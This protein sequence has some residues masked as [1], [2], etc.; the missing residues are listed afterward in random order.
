MKILYYLP[1]LEAPG[2]LERIITFKANY[3]AEHGDEVTI[4]TSEME[5]TKPHFALSPRVRHVDLGVAFDYPYSQSRVMKLLKY[6]FRYRRF[7]KRLVR[8]LHELRPD[9]TVSTLRRELNFLNDVKDGSVKI[10]EFH[11]TRHA[12]GAEA[13]TSGNA[14]MRKLKGMWNKRFV[15]NLSRLSRVVL[16]TH[17]EAGFWPELNNLCVIPNPII[18][19]LDKVSDGTPRRVIAAGRYAPQK[20]FDALIDSWALVAHKHP[21]WTLHIY[22]DG[23]LREGLQAQIE[24][25]RLTESCFLEHNA[26]NIADKYCES[27]IFVL[28]SR[29]EGFGMVITEAMGCGVAPVCFACPCGPRDIIDDGKNG[30]LVENGSIREMAQKISYLIENEEIR[31]EMGRQAYRDA[32]KY[33]MEH[34]AQQWKDLFQSLTEQKNNK[35]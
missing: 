33:K 13:L 31:K 32:Q 21:S 25:L 28:S 11:V 9:I 19:P 18:T 17:E 4:V 26:D 14:L 20:G 7:R 35:V 27:S 5:R 24:H 1:S 22:G 16:L 3:F 15:N 8:T 34:I 6:P 12:Y 2:G 10:G 30:L 23:Y 29:Y